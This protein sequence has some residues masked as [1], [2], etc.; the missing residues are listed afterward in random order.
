MNNKI[1]NLL[2]IMTVILILQCSK[3]SQAKPIQKSI[4]TTTEASKPKKK[5]PQIGACS[6]NF[7]SM[8]KGFWVE[9]PHKHKAKILENDLPDE[10]L[11]N[12]N[13]E[14]LMLQYCR[15]KYIRATR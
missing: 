8:Y 3:N 14:T 4:T 1:R 12:L 5:A 9:V 11:I 6:K 2:M 15:R 7:M 10:S 13:L